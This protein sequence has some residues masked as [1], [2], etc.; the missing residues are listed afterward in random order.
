ME[1][2]AKS[3]EHLRGKR[4]H[5]TAIDIDRF[6]HGAVAACWSNMDEPGLLQQPGVIP[7]EK[8]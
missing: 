4:F 5:I 6:Q 2:T 8:M 3:K 1:N 7:N